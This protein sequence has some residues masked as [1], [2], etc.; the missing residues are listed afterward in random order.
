MTPVDCCTALSDSDGVEYRGGVVAYKNFPF[1][2]AFLCFFLNASA[3]S[4]MLMGGPFLSMLLML[5][6]FNE[7]QNQASSP[8]V[9]YQCADVTPK[10]LSAL[11]SCSWACLN[12]PYNVRLSVV[13]P[14]TQYF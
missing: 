2:F 7:Y 12:V 1:T 8:G 9:Q 13:V 10:S 5:V 4:L 14:R 11:M 6:V 3:C